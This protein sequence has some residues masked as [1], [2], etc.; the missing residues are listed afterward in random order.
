MDNDSTAP[1][2]APTYT[3]TSLEEMEQIRQRHLRGEVIP[4]ELIKAA[5][6]FART[7][8][9]PTVGRPAKQAIAGSTASGA[10]PRSNKP[11]LADFAD[12]LNFGPPPPPPEVKP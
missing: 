11:S 5:L 7:Q 10:K 1:Q 6:A 12:L 9:L 4:R 3:V 2:A 8:R